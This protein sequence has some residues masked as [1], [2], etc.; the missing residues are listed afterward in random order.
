MM[1]SLDLKLNDG[2]IVWS[3]LKIKLNVILI[4]S[5]I[6]NSQPEP[7]MYTNYEGY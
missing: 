4:Y 7:N 3:A 2:S 5:V 1:T 6:V